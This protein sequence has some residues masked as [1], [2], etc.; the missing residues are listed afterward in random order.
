MPTYDYECSGCGHRFEVFESVHAS[1]RK[2]CPECKARKAK[3]QIGIGAGVLFKGS[4]FY[5]TDYAKKSTGST[6]SSSESKPSCPAAEGCGNK[7][8]LASKKKD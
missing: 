7:C 5:T 3:R 8:E 1:G 6:S 2:A 4:G